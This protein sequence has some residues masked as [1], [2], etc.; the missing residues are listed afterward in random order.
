V[1]LARAVLLNPK[2]IL[3]DEPTASLDDAAAFDAIHVLLA[4]AQR[5]NATL[6]IATHDARVGA[7]MP[8]GT[9]L[10]R[11]C[12]SQPDDLAHGL[13]NKTPDGVENKASNWPLAPVVNA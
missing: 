10:S 5:L 1:A 3:A 12:F 4:T 6:V 11:V 2:V 13:Q 9:A 8:A 7:L